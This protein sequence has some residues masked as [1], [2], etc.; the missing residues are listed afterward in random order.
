MSRRARRPHVR[1]TSFELRPDDVILTKRELAFHL[2]LSVRTVER[3]ACPTLRNEQRPGARG[4]RFR[5]RYVKRLALEYFAQRLRAPRDT[6][7]DA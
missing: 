7:G 6:W 3:S 4:V 1:A 2:R 5:H